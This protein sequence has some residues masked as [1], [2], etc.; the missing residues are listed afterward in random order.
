MYEKM[1]TDMLR[2]I[3][4]PGNITS[5]SHC[6]TRLRFV[7]KDPAKADKQALEQ[8]TGVMKVVEAS[9]QVQIVIGNE[10]A[11]VYKALL[12]KA[13]ELKGADQAASA[14]QK[15]PFSFKS[16]LNAIA[17]IFTPTIP[18]LAGAGVIKGILVLLTT[19]GLLASDTGTYQI[20]NAAAD[21]IFYFMPVILGYTSAKIF[22]CNIPISMAI[23][24]SLI[25]PNLVSF[26]SGAESV[27]FLGIPVINTTYG[28]TVIPII[29]A[30]LVYS[31]LEKILD[32]IIPNMVKSVISPLISL[33]VMVPATMLVFGPFGNYTSQMIGV[34]FQK[35]TAV[36]PLIAGAFFGGVYSILVMFG[37]HRALVPI[38]I[39]EVSTFG[40]TALWAFTGPANFA[41]AGASFGS[42][43]RLKDKEMKSVAL[44][45]SITALFGITEP[46]LYGV[47][48]KY[49]RPMIAVVISG[50]V[51]GAIAGIGG[52]RAY[53]VAIPSI[54]TLPTFF[55]PGFAAFLIAIAAAFVLGAVITVILGLDEG[56]SAPKKSDVPAV[57]EESSNEIASPLN[58]QVVSLSEVKD[59]TFATGVLGYGCGVIPS[60]GKLYAPVSGEISSLVDTH[61]AFG[62]SAGDDMELLIHIGIDT[63]QLN[64]KYFKTHIKT[65]DRVSKGDLLIEFDREAI[66][67]AGYDTTTMVVVVGSEE[68][69]LDIAAAGKIGRGDRLISIK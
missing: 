3:G 33:I 37:M 1:I 9:G 62:I 30:T 28:A 43:L 41:Q 50:A 49:K 66:Q 8:L 45:A 18:A 67:K 11:K 61:H 29:L 12:E 23:G 54:L 65:G 31:K 16:V 46:A 63:V 19:Y 38:G 69:D 44:S 55:G 7:L 57:E 48:L 6:F 51:G 26:M 60:D 42:F 10:V 58:G 2:N 4:G 64:G 15:E 17:S 68:A 56:G 22:G 21:S 36:S 59:E 34:F 5:V 27:T 13:P 20:L 35:I 25:Y 40:S 24:G 52:A 47:N 32:R 14:D 39:N 53:A